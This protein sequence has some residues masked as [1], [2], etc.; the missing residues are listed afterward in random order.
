M[1]AVDL[2]ELTKLTIGHDGKGVGSGWFLD[3]V[4]VQLD[5]KDTVFDCNR[6]VSSHNSLYYNTCVPSYYEL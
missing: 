6:Y 2:G 1:E 3:K 5:G 4:V